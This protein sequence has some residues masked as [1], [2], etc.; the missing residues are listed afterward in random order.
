MSEH[1]IPVTEDE[2]HAYVDGELPADRR[3]AV[4][5]WLATH[6][7]DAARVAS[8]R[9]IAETVRARYSG[10]ADEPVPQRLDLDRLGK[11]PLRWAMGMAAAAA[12]AFVIGGGVGWFAHGA[13]AAVAAKDPVDAMRN[14]AT[15]AH[16]LY[17]REMRHPIEVRANE[18]HLLPWLSRR[19]GTKL[20]APD[21]AAFDLKLLGGRLLP[22]LQG[23][24]ALFM[25]E[26]GSGERVTIYC[27]PLNA[28]STSFKYRDGHNKIASVDWVADNYG[29]VISG[30][31]DK[32][33]LKSVAMAAWQQM[34][35]K[36]R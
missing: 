34:E 11:R 16:Q 14:E 13:S 4:E 21:L 5:A 35:T 2:L 30:P 25:Y 7:E 33:R 23:P 1:E 20:T 28:A 22:G 31:Q 19:L 12:F 8:W 15:A 18:D 26:T 36:P 27:T 3:T 10:V 32:P 17:I 24:A 9:Q 6:A 29:W